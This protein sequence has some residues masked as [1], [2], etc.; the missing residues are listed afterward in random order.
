MI[1]TAVTTLL[2][3]LSSLPVVGSIFGSLS[4]LLG[5]LGSLTSITSDRRLKSDV[6][7]V[8]WSR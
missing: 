2:S 5:S 3:G 1:P 8:G 6:V 4:T 7:A